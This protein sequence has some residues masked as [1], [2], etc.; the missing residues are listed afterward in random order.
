MSYPV[1]KMPLVG[2]LVP[3]LWYAM[4]F[5]GHGLNT[6]TMAGQLVAGAIADGDDRYRL[7]APFG[8]LPAGGPIGAGAAQLT[9]WYYQMVDAW[10]AMRTHG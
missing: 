1:H 10:R 7:L 5:G 9:Y 8:L 4:G 2:E 6:T 3:G